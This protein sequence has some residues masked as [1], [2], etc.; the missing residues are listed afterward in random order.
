MAEAHLPRL[1]TLEKEVMEILWDCPTE[2]CTRDVLEQTSQTLAY[3]TI[4]T[5]LNN[6]VKK[7]LVERVPAGR[8][9]AY[10]PLHDRGAYVAGLMTEALSSSA[11]REASLLHFVESMS[12]GDVALLRGLLADGGTGRGTDGQSSP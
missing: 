1:G 3:T 6:L 4:A 7:G 10:R 2:L 8:T 9:W 5:V 12:D 11:D